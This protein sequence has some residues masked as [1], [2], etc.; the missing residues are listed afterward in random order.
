MMHL[1]ADSIPPMETLAEAAEAH[2]RQEHGTAIGLDNVAA[3]DRILHAE[4]RR[5]DPERLESVAAC[6]GAW[7]GRLSRCWPRDGPP[8]RP[9]RWAARCAARRSC[10]A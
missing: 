4:S 8:P 5:L 1:V 10:R 3:A 2:A 7:L 9:R 6:Y